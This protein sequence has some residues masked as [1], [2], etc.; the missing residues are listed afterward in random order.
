MF[1]SNLWRV[2]QSIFI[3]KKFHTKQQRFTLPFLQP[4]FDNIP[5]EIKNLSKAE[6]RRIKDYPTLFIVLFVELF[7]ELRQKDVSEEERARLTLFSASLAIYDDFFDNT[8]LDDNYILEIYQNPQKIQFH[9]AQ[10]RVFFEIMDVFYQYFPKEHPNFFIFQEKFKEFWFFQKES[11]K[12]LQKE[13]LSPE[14]LR[15]IS[16]GKG[17]TALLLS[18]LLMDNTATKKEME[19]VQNMGAWFQWFDDIVDIAQDIQKNT[20]TLIINTTKIKEAREEV[21]Q[22]T[23]KV[24]D[25]MRTLDYS[26]TIM[27]KVLHQFFVISTSGFIHLNQLEKLEKKSKNQ[28]KPHQYTHKELLWREND[29]L[30]FVRA[31]KIWIFYRF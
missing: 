17:G 25:E 9:S 7:A 29:K 18:R 10:E 13:K 2:P 5:E 12:Q 27:K 24:F 30:N 22:I 16:F 1:F 23:Q 4:I 6:W 11:R 19:V 28:F 20:Q 3:L 31:L 26:P 14:E 15:K 8:N 21:K